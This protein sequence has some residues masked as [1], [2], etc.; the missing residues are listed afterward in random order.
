MNHDHEEI[1]RSLSSP[2]CGMLFSPSVVGLAGHYRSAIK[3]GVHFTLHGPSVAIV[4]HLLQKGSST[5]WP[6]LLEAAEQRFVRVL[7]RLY[8]P[9]PRD[10]ATTVAVMDAIAPVYESIIDTG[11]NQENIAQLFVAL[12]EAQPHVAG[13]LHVLDFGCGTGLSAE[14]S[15]HMLT[16]QRFAVVGLDESPRMRAL[17]SARG[18]AIVHRGANIRCHGV[19]ASYVLHGGI[20]ECDL[21]WIMRILRP[22]GTF[23][24]NWLHGTR[25]GIESLFSDM[26]RHRNGSGRIIDR[27]GIWADDPIIMFECADDE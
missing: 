13:P 27:D 1:L 9:L 14:V 20:R 19:L 21:A 8:M 3:F 18:L 26:R 16:E 17:A 10:A 5:H 4:A 23:A 15:T 24:A 7:D 25:R 6:H 11:R 22:R 2:D 12:D